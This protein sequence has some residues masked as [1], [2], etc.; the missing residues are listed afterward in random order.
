MPEFFWDIKSLCEDSFPGGFLTYGKTDVISDE[1]L[2]GQS[3]T[4]TAINRLVFAAL[5]DDKTIVG[6]QYAT[7]CIHNYYE[8]IKGLNLNIPNDLYNDNIRDYYY[9]GGCQSLKGP[10]GEERIWK[11][12]TNW[13]NADN[14]MGI[15]KVYGDDKIT[16]YSPGRRQIGTHDT[17]RGYGL[18]F[19]HADQICFSFIKDSSGVLPGTVL[20]DIGYVIRVG[21][22]AEETAK[23]SKEGSIKKLQVLNLF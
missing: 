11:C 2:E 9:N 22:T 5:P 16:V 20:Y 10:S 12:H 18:G 19:M 15:F 6:M 21:E 7:S 13:I 4:R 1:Y 17:I 23:F 8:S 14:C 3:K